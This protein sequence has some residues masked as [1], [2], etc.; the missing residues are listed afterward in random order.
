MLASQYLKISLLSMAVLS[1]SAI[2]RNSAPSCA[3]AALP[4]QTVTEA[5][6]VW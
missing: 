1:G 2:R 5:A 3:P 6:S 4:F